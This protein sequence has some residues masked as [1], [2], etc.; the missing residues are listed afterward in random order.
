MIYIDPALL[1][2]ESKEETP[3]AGPTLRPPVCLPDGRA[4]RSP[5][6]R[7]EVAAPSDAHDTA[8][9]NGPTFGSCPSPYV[10]KAIQRLDTLLD[11][12][13]TKEKRSARTKR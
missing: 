3:A 6:Q 1:A 4:I 11:E 13:K 2:R 12:R 5:R 7:R 9:W 8:A 10:A